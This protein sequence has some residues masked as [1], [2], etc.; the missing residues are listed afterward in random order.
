MAK[1]QIVGYKLIDEKTQQPIDQWGGIWGVCP[2]TPNPLTLPTG[3]QIWGAKVGESYNGFYLEAWEMEQPAP[4]SD[5]VNRE[6]DRRVDDGFLLDGQKFQSRP[7]DRENIAGASTL[8][9]I[10]IMGGAQPGDLRWHGG[11]TNFVWIASDNSLVP[12]D[13]YTVINLGKTAAAWKS[14][15]IFAARVLKDMEE[16]PMNYTDDKYWEV[17]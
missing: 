17:V 4:T 14:A 16:I 8:A 9:V 3:N 15:H 7:K 2:G 1:T 5:D 12:M 11:S 10:A 6:R 13:A